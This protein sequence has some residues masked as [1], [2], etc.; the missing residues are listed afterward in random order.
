MEQLQKR[1]WYFSYLKYPISSIYHLL[2]N[3]AQSIT[4]V[5]Q[6]SI[7]YSR[8]C[9]GCLRCQPSLAEQYQTS[10]QQQ[11]L[12][13]RTS[14]FSRVYQSNR[15]NQKPANVPQLSPPVENPDCG[16]EYCLDINQTP[17]ELHATTTNDEHSFQVDIYEQIERFNYDQEK[18]H[19]QSLNVQHI[20]FHPNV[21]LIA[22]HLLIDHEKVDLTKLSN[23]IHALTD[24]RVELSEKSLK[25]IQ[26]NPQST[27]VKKPAKNELEE[28]ALEKT[29]IFLF[30]RRSQHHPSSS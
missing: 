13:T 11:Q 5:D 27:F 14:F 29:G 23:G 15:S 1:L 22:K 21:N 2:T 3:P 8:P 18:P 24:V 10:Q 7:T 30:P 25:F 28:D 12:Q 9:S 20:R 17:I 4:S 6:P 26:I 19:R 16:V